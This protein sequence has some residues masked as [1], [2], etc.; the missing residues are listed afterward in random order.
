MSS[1]VDVRELEGT[2]VA[3]VVRGQGYF[4]VIA[5]LG[6]DECVVVLRGGAGHLGLGGRLD[7][8]RSIDGG[9]TWEDPVTVADSE[10]DDRNPALGVA[11][12]GSLVLAYHWQGSYG[13]DGKWSPDDRQVDSRLVY[14]RDGGRTWEGDRPL[15]FEPLNG[16]SPFGKIRCGDDGALYMPIY[17]G[18]PPLADLTPGVRAGDGQNPA[19]NQCGTYL[20]RSRDNGFTWSEPILVALGLNEA[21][22]LPLPN[23]EWLFAARSEKR[24]EAAIYTCRSAD[25]GATWGELGRVT[26]NSEHPPD[27]TLL[28]SGDVLL[29]FGCRN[30]PFGVQGLVSRDGGRTWGDRRLL[31]A[32]D[33]P[34]FDIGYPSTVLLEGGRLVTVFYSAGTPEEP[35]NTYEAVNAFCRAV[36]YDETAVL[37]ALA[38]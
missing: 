30:A 28:S 10:R 8:V 4:P 19:D 33:L 12:D 29:T 21:D 35:G 36:C 31:Y 16:A 37:A 26:G 25:A 2:A 7:A 15:G 23:G 38:D 24:G 11:A 34:G 32:D 9:L 1:P 22:V 5:G 6:G 18:G 13:P 27:L 3:D 20:L 17:G 14:S